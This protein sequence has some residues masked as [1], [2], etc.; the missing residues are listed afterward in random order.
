MWRQG[1][2]QHLADQIDQGVLRL[3][4][5]MELAPK[6]AHDLALKAYRLCEDGV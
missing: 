3:S 2:S 6:L 1:V 5:A 4:D